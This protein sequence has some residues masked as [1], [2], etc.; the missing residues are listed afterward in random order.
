MEAAEFGLS[1]GFDDEG[2]GGGDYGFEGEGLEKGARGGFSLAAGEGGFDF[3]FGDAGFFG[4]G[5]DVCEVGV[6]GWVGAVY[7]LEC[8]GEVWLR[9]V[10]VG[11]GTTHICKRQLSAG[12]RRGWFA[13]FCGR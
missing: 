5:D 11:S 9:W 1:F 13:F 7:F 6:V 12:C 2:D 4:G 8:K 10:V 3:F